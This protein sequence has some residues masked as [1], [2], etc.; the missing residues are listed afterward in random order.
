MHSCG[1]VSLVHMHFVPSWD[2]H[3]HYVYMPLMIMWDYPI[4][5]RKTFPYTQLCSYFLFP[6][7]EFLIHCHVGARGWWD[8]HMLIQFYPLAFPH[9]NIF[10]TIN[11]LS[12]LLL[13][14]GSGRVS[15]PPLAP[16]VLRSIQF[17]SPLLDA[18]LTSKAH[19]FLSKQRLL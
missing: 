4:Q 14:N 10:E 3:P 5:L 18:N 11:F 9:T 16:H 17:S 7:T 12:N 15:W 19:G 13:P 2:A 8:S 6:A 1:L